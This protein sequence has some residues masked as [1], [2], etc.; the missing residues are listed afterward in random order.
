LCDAGGYARRGAGCGRVEKVIVID[1]PKWMGGKV[2][3]ALPARWGAVVFYPL[4]SLVPAA[5]LGGR[6]TV[7]AILGGLLVAVVTVYAVRIARMA[8]IVDDFGVTVRNTW[9]TWRCPWTEVRG[10]EVP[11]SALLPIAVP[12][13]RCTSGRRIRLSA[14]TVSRGGLVWGSGGLVGQDWV[15]QQ[16]VFLTWEMQERRPRRS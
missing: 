1:S 16:V 12:H 4:V 7:G 15:E 5:F 6:G 13:M 10:F 14:L 2:V 9:R 3:Y 8:V 11:G